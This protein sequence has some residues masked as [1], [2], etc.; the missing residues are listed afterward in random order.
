MNSERRRE[1]RQVV[2]RACKVVT[3]GGVRFL[4]GRTRDVSARG[5]LV[6]VEGGRVLRGGEEIA[7]AVDWRGAAVVANAE[8]LRGRVVRALRGPSGEQCVAVEFAAA[9]GE[10]ALAAV[11]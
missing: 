10:Q 8:V 4:P 5:A 7:L 1:V 11:A 6:T 2:E 9:A 3:C